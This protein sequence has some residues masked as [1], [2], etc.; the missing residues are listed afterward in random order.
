MTENNTPHDKV[1]LPL[2]LHKWASNF[3]WLCSYLKL[4]HQF[5]VLKV[6]SDR[7][8]IVP[9]NVLPI[10]NGSWLWSIFHK[11]IWINFLFF[12]EWA[13]TF[14]GYKPLLILKKYGCIYRHLTNNGSSVTAFIWRGRAWQ[15]HNLLSW[16]PCLQQVVDSPSLQQLQFSL[17]ALEKCIHLQ[18]ISITRPS[19]NQQKYRL[20]RCLFVNQC[21][22]GRVHSKCSFCIYIV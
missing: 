14:T 8:D 4:W 6:C 3:Q 2:L 1:V 15:I 13:E 22:R 20:I 5:H 18:Y 16:Y 7:D 17:R 10:R 12:L 21:Q 11:Q 19:S 9:L